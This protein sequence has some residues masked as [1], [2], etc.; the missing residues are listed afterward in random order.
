VTG[1]VLSAHQRAVV[2]AAVRHPEL[3]ARGLGGLLRMSEGSVRSA[4]SRAYQVL[5][6]RSRVELARALDGL[7]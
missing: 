7:R 2:E 3:G 6:I 4:L 1:P 5:G